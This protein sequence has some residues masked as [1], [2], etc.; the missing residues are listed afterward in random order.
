MSNGE[1]RDAHLACQVTG[2]MFVLSDHQTQIVVSRADV[3]AAEVAYAMFNRW[4]QDNY[5]R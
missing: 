2:G 1:A 3:P 4:R 5:F